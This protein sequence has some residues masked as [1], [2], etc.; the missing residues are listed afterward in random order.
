MAHAQTEIRLPQYQGYISV[1][2]NGRYFVDEAGQGFLVI[3]QNDGV[4]WPGLVT[5]LND[6]SREATENYIRDLRAH[7][8]T[9]SRIMMEYSQEEYTYLENPVGTFSEPVVKFWDDFI[10]LAEEHGLYLLLTPYDTFWQAR[11]WGRYPYNGE[12]GGPCATPN[13]WLTA[14][15]C[16]DAHKARWRFI[17][18]RWGGSPNIFAWDIMNEIDI[19]WSATTDEIRAYI[20]EMAAFIRDYEMQRWGRTHLLTVSSAAAIPEGELGRIIYQHP[21]LD[22]ANTHLYIGPDIKSPDDPV[23]AG[24]MMAGGVTLSLQ[25]IDEPRPYMDTE[26]GPIDRWIADP[27]FDAEYHHNMSWAHLAA[28]GAGSGMRWPYTTP[29]WILP[30]MRDNLLALARFAAAVDW[31]N[32]DSHPIGSNL[33]IDDRNIIRVGISD[34]STAIVWL[35]RDTRDGKNPSLSGRLLQINRTLADGS[36]RVEFWDT[37]S[38]TPLTDLTAMVEDNQLRL[39]LPDLADAKDVALLIRPAANGGG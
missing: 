36:Y 6:L 21:L 2:P 25:S 38:G 31:A 18:D 24:P 27:Q 9:V 10:A 35:L 16:I 34:G 7:G 29:H 30:E 13:D 17:L 1:A 22:F 23:G 4:P 3:G 37:Q 28:G 5:L 15:P 14:R 26:S 19:W 20:D 39:T 32:F 33:L 8:I 11:N 12:L